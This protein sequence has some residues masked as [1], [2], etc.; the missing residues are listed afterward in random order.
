M[1][2]GFGEIVPISWE[3]ATFP[4]STFTREH[5]A[6]IIQQWSKGP[7]AVHNDRLRQAHKQAIDAKRR[8]EYEAASEREGF[9]RWPDVEN[10]NALEPERA[11]A[12]APVQPTASNCK[13]QQGS[14]R[15]PAT[16]GSS[17]SV[18]ELLLRLPLTRAQDWQAKHKKQDDMEK[19][20]AYPDNKKGCAA[21]DCQF[22]HFPADSHALQ[23]GTP[24]TGCGEW[25]CH[26]CNVRE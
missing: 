10:E 18:S 9:G 5:R 17:V 25:K 2:L 4:G 20:K 12:A 6:R 7:I 21:P 14:I 3:D 8:N 1:D 22:D 16:S 11:A 23:Y 26:M 19:K 15:G 13:A 24:G